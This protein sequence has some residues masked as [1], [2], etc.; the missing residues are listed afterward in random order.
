MQGLEYQ[1]ARI[2][3]IHFGRLPFSPPI[4]S[5]LANY[6]TVLPKHDWDLSSSLLL[7]C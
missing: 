3:E 2:I 1:G 4:S 6:V 7:N 5:K